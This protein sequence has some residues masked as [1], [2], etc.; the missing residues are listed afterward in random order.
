M[1][2]RASVAFGVFAGMVIAKLFILENRWQGDSTP[3]LAYLG[4]AVLAL[5]WAWIV[6]EK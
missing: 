2:L 4:A 1:N 3:F 6:W 5:A